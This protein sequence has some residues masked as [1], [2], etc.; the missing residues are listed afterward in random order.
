MSLPEI[1]IQESPK[2]RKG[3]IISPREEGRKIKVRIKK[4]EL[5][6]KLRRGRTQRKEDIDL[7]LPLDI[8]HICND[9][10]NSVEL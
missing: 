4:Q 9:K 7:E 6:N 3:N 1:E 8:T 2:E 10:N 5:P